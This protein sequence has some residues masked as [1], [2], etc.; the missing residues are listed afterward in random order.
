MPSVNGFPLVLNQEVPLGHGYA[1]E[2]FRAEHYDATSGG[3]GVGSPTALK[4]QAQS[5]PDGTIRT[6]PGGATLRSTYAGH[7]GQSYHTYFGPRTVPVSPTGSASGGRTDLV[8]VQLCDPEHDNHW[9]Y[10]GEYPIPAETAVT[11]D[12]QRI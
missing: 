1:A 10:S 4:V 2:A 8:V 12:F 5:A 3:N 6:N 11:L 7:I 9:S